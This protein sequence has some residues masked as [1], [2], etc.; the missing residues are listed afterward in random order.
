MSRA[1]ITRLQPVRSGIQALM[2]SPEMVSGLQQTAEQVAM[3][4][5]LAASSVAQTPPR[6][7]PY[8]GHA[9]LLKY[10]AVGVVRPTTKQGKAIEAKYHILARFGGS[11]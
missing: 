8:K 6:M 2:K 5:S 1:T 10:T 4:A 3:D 11:R 7:A 9:K